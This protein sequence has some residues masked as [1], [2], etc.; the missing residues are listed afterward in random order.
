MLEVKKDGTLEMNWYMGNAKTK[1][2]NPILVKK[3][4]GSMKLEYGEGNLFG[5]RR[6]LPFTDKDGNLEER[7]TKI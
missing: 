1:E 3:S 7:W 2:E 5:I 4:D 6:R